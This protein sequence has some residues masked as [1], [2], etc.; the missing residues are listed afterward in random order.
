MTEKNVRP[1]EVVATLR[2]LESVIPEFR[3]LTQ[4]QIIAL[5][6]AATLRPDWV[7][8]ATIAIGTCSTVQS[9]VAT[10]Y[11]ELQTETQDIHRW[12]EVES[13]L[14]ALLRGVEC[15]NLIRRHRVG[16]KALQV[17]GICKQLVRQPEHAK[18]QSIYEEL[19]QKNKLGRRK[20]K[21]EAVTE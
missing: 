4:E 11:E 8:L 3:Q 6:R 13:Q 21:A 10:S 17:Y 20:K 7:E 15:A 18:L 12:E 5:R 14:R 9:A 16:L 19:K 1:D 2:S